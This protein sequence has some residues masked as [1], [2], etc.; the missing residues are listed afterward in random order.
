M[1][2]RFQFAA[3]AVNILL[4][5]SRVLILLLGVFVVWPTVAL[6]IDAPSGALGRVDGRDVSVEGGLSGLNDGDSTAMA[7]RYVSSGS[8]ITVHSAKARMTIF[9][10]GKVDICGPAQFTVLLSGDAITLA[11][12]FGRVRVDIPANT[13]LR[14]FTPTIIG[15]PLDISGGSR[16]VTQSA[17][18]STDSL[19][20]LA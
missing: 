10:G 14:I 4:R 15:T 3:P 18:I 2:A 17:L 16:D 20:V 19:C 6:A 7:G 13:T 12:N 11:L 8:V 9:S 5:S 1:N